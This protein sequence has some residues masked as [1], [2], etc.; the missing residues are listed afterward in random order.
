MKAFNSFGFKHYDGVHW[1][2]RISVYDAK[3]GWD[4]Q[5]HLGKEFYGDFWAYDVELTF[6]DNF[7]VEATGN[8]TNNDEVLP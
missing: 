4:T 5:Q 1:Y 7:V 3:F 6:A 2:P 8:L